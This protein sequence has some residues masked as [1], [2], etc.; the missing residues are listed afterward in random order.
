MTTVPAAAAAAA[1][2]ASAR[3]GADAR[4]AVAAGVPAPAP[5]AED[6]HADADTR[7]GAGP[8]PV[9]LVEVLRQRLSVLR[10]KTTTLG[11]PPPHHLGNFLRSIV[12]G[13]R[14]AGVSQADAAVRDRL[15]DGL[16]TLHWDAPR[17]CSLGDAPPSY[18]DVLSWLEQETQ[19]S[20][21]VEDG[22]L[23]VTAFEVRMAAPMSALLDEL[24][25]Q[26]PNWRD[27]KVSA[28][29]G[30]QGKGNKRAAASPGSPRS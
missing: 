5:T 19:S 11:P 10:E 15:R 12:D 18:A 21:D 26:D 9:A 20:V 22:D 29:S 17:N 24:G 3:D 7:V 8:T 27:V 25:T 30:A 16:A 4:P 6:A 23:P 2:V 1:A 14:R 28:A 13:L